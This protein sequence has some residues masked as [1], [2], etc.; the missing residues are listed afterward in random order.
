MYTRILGTMHNAAVMDRH[1]LQLFVHVQIDQCHQLLYLA[2][3]KRYL[4]IVR[5]NSD[6]EI[7]QNQLTLRISE[8]FSRILPASRQLSR[9][10]FILF[11][12]LISGFMD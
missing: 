11:S 5:V 1:L 2:M 10:F 7:H 3:N 12:I 9:I 6:K 4:F 8:H